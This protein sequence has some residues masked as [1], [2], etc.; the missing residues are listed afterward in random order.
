MHFR[1]LSF[2]FGLL[3]AIG[4]AF[5]HQVWAQQ[6]A[7][8]D[9]PPKK[10]DAISIKLPTEDQRSP[11]AS[12]EVSIAPA[13]AKPGDEVTLKVAA[14]IAD[15]WHIYPVELPKDAAGLATEIKLE[16]DNLSA[17][18]K[19]FVPSSKP[20]V[21][22]KD[23][24]TVASH[25]GE[26]SWTRKYTVSKSG[27]SQVSGSIEFQV[28][29]EESCLPPKTLKFNLKA[30][31]S[32]R[33]PT[34]K[35]KPSHPVIGA[36]I[37]VELAKCRSTRPKAKLSLLGV[38]FGSQ[39][40]TLS[41]KGVFQHEGKDVSIYLPAVRKFRL[42]STSGHTRVES[43]ATYLSIDH[44]SNGTIEDWESFSAHRPFRVADSMYQVTEIDADQNRLTLCRVDTPISGSIVGRKIAPFSLTTL[45]GQVVSDKSIVGKVTLLD[46]WA[47]T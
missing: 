36:P 14:R 23:G 43:N 29:N 44:D 41:L 4:F 33:R 9:S 35:V 24:L 16:G 26:I 13:T 11:A 2:R 47:V 6:E 28:C 7:I 18:G 17:T 34:A 31:R 46:V 3:L 21:V 20:E 30:P 10:K 22:S 8:Q 38:L 42:I 25:H 27:I 40:E 39:T 15:G 12:F 5:A 32:R 1:T 19:G 45:D 37:V